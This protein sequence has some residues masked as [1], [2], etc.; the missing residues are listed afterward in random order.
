LSH[1]ESYHTERICVFLKYYFPKHIHIFAGKSASQQVSKSASQ[2][3]SKSAS[4]QVSKSA[5]QQVS[6]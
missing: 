2:Q 3:V 1:Q 6:K 4:Q 5:S